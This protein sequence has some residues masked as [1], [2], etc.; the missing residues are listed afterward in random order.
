MNKKDVSRVN[1]QGCSVLYFDDDPGLT[2]QHHKNECDI[3]NIMSKFSPDVLTAHALNYAGNYGDY[4][5]MPDYHTAL[6]MI[7]QIDNMFLDV[8]AEIRAKFNN[9]PASFIDFVN[10]PDNREAMVELGLVVPSSQF[11]IP[12]KE[13]FNES[14]ASETPGST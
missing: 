1:Y 4:S 13:T 2:E 6:N 14:E 5:D 7:R 8:P 11:N 10:N 12:P 9:D 3:N